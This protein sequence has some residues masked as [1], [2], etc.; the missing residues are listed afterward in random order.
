LNYAEPRGKVV[1]ACGTGK[2]AMGDTAILVEQKTAMAARLWEERLAEL[3]AFK[4]MPEHGHC[5]V[6][7]SYPANPQLGVWVQTQRKQKERYAADPADSQLTAERMKRLD[8]L[9]F[10]WDLSP[11]AWEERLAELVAF[12]AMPGYGHY[13]V[14]VSEA[15]PENKQLG[16]WVTRQRAEKMK[17]DA[18]PATSQI[19]AERVAKL[20]ALG[21]PWHPRA[22]AWE[23]KLMQLMAFKAMPQHG[24]CNVPRGYLA[25]KHLGKWVDKQR[26]EKK[27]YNADPTTSQLMAER[28]EKLEALGFAW[29]L[30]AV[31]WEEKLAELADFKALSEHGHC[32]VPQRY[33][34]N[35]QLGAWVSRQRTEKTKYDADPATSTLTAER[36]DK[37]EALGFAW[38]WS[39]RG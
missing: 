10:A 36:V 8:A 1:M 11:V 7:K 28:V 14:P 15:Y 19:T 34:A 29:D 5:N 24:H 13:I 31:A 21:F 2:Q 18:N 37:L 17:Y 27:K 4:A 39:L 30:Q 16:K 22:A 26:K 25:N 32:S 3:V 38:T 9:G 23:E 12:K 33:A 35:P 6:P 20:E